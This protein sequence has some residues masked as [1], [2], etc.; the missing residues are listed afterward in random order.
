MKRIPEWVLGVVVIAIF[1]GMAVYFSNREDEFKK[2]DPKGYEAMMEEA[3][4]EGI[5]DP[6]R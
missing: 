3:R 5:P 2:V 4:A 1:A 6:R